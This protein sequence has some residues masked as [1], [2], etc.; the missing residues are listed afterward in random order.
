M[1][2]FMNKNEK[3]KPNEID[4]DDNYNI[5]NLMHLCSNSFTNARFEIN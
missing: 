1:A 4:A 2:K 3:H 5:C